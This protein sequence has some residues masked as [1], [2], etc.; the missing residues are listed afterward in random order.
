MRV[1]EQVASVQ[2]NLTTAFPGSRLTC[3]IRRDCRAVELHFEGT[4]QSVHVLPG[5]L[6]RELNPLPVYCVPGQ[7]N[8]AKEA[9]MHAQAAIDAQR[10][11][12]N[13]V[14]NRRWKAI[15]RRKV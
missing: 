3:G 14:A 5:F 6:T 13:R 8:Q 1:P 2:I 10:D 4:D 9:A 12:N 11:R 15:F 7:N